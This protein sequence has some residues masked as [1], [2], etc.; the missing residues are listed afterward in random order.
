MEDRN[1]WD[2]CVDGCNKKTDLVL[3]VD[4]ALKHQLQQRGYCVAFLDHLVSND[5][6]EPLNFKLHDF[7]HTWFKDKN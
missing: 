6:L 2:L 4:F 3:C 5:V 1:L 7:L